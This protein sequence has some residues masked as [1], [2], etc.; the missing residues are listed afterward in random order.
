MTLFKPFDDQ[1]SFIAINGA[2]GFL[3]DLVDPLAVD[4]TTTYRRRN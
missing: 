1:P 3:L 4:K 2:I